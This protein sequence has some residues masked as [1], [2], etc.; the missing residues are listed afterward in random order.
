M[1]RSFVKIMALALVAILVL[2]TVSCGKKLTIDDE[3]MDWNLDF[4]T[5]ESAT[6]VV[7]C[8]AEYK[9]SY[10][11]TDVEILDLS[12]RAANGKFVILNE[13]TDMGYYGIYIE[14]GPDYPKNGYYVEIG[15]GD[16]KT[17]G[18]AEIT[19]VTLHDDTIE[20]N[21]TIVLNNGYSLNFKSIED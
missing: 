20:Y 9:E 12:C 7:Y 3:N 2:S 6:N 21:L 16:E 1:K 18:T 11:E 14:G 4:I 5:Y 13:K 17:K 10:L 19:K 8:S 15:D